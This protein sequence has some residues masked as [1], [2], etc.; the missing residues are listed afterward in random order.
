MTFIKEGERAWTVPV[1]GGRRRVKRVYLNQLCEILG[2]DDDED[3]L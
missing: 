1:V 2:L 3:R